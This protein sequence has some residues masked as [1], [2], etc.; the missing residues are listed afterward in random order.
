MFA[1]LKKIFMSKKVEGTSAAAPVDAPAAPEETA[2]ENMTGTEETADET[3]S[4]DMK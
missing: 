1:W 2:A 3:S 4:E